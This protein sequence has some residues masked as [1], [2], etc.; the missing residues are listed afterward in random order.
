MQALL[1]DG[2]IPTHGVE[3]EANLEGWIAALLS[4]V[5]DDGSGGVIRPVGRPAAVTVHVKF[6]V[7][8]CDDRRPGSVLLLQ[9][10][11]PGRFVGSMVE[12]ELVCLVEAGSTVLV[13]DGRT[14]ETLVVVDFRSRVLVVGVRREEVLVVDGRHHVLSLAWPRVVDNVVLLL[15]ENCW[16]QRLVGGLMGRGLVVGQGWCG[17]PVGR[18]VGLSCWVVGRLLRW[19]RLVRRR[20]WS[21]R[22]RGRRGG[23]VLRSWSRLWRLE[24]VGGIPGRRRRFM[25]LNMMLGHLVVSGEWRSVVVLWVRVGPEVT[26]ILRRCGVKHDGYILLGVIASTVMLVTTRRLILGG[27]R[28]ILIKAGLTGRRRADIS[29]LAYRRPII[30]D[31]GV[32]AVWSSVPLAVIGQDVLDAA[33]IG[34]HFDAGQPDPGMPRRWPVNRRPFLSILKIDSALRENVGHIVEPSVVVVHVAVTVQRWP[35]LVIAGLSDG[36]ILLPRRV[37]SDTS[38]VPTSVRVES[39]AGETITGG[40]HPHPVLEGGLR[41]DRDQFIVDNG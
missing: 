13:L 30:V 2:T 5:V 33:G 21:V 18:L 37:F 3:V 41:V 20:G 17:R 12:R 6:V 22:L 29:A 26:W 23:I 39:S 32:L 40:R 31:D 10:D 16:I 4:V 36:H 25:V 11:R 1:A 28:R 34:R 15:V 35:A 24:V 19:H 27:R 9:V 14:V 8:V 7:L 38:E